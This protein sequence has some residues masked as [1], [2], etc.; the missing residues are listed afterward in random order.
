MRIELA[1]AQ[2]AL[3]DWFAGKLPGASQISVSE[4][5]APGAG[6]SNETY[7]VTLEYTRDGISHSDEF[8]IRWPPSGF[9][10]FPEHAYD[11][12]RQYHLLK[13]L[14]DTDLPTP[15]VFGLETNSNILG[16]PF[17]VMKKYQAGYLVI[18]RL[19]IRLADYL[20]QSLTRKLRSGGRGW[21][22]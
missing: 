19:I 4:L 1:R 13:C 16:A 11:M 14:Q 7:F 20:T 18:F 17:F 9:L 10:V 6:A 15:P 3:P 2:Q 22:Q 8:V 12:S 5:S 21:R